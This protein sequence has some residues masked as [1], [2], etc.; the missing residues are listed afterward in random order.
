MTEKITYIAFDGSE[1]ANEDECLEYEAE[2]NFGAFKDHV[3]L[4]DD[5]RRLMPFSLDN[6]EACSYIS[7]NNDRAAAS[8]VAA[9]EEEGYS[10]LPRAKGVYKYNTRKDK[11][12]NLHEKLADLTELIKELAAYENEN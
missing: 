8:F 11:W 2:L 10:E 4:F 9:M 6:F 3:F 5:K 1:F 7:I 12:E